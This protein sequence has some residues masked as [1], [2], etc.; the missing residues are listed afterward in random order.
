MFAVKSI[1]IVADLIEW[2]ACEL[3]LADDLAAKQRQLHKK[4]LLEFHPVAR[5]R[6]F[7]GRTGKMDRPQGLPAGH[8]ALGPHDLLRQRF[9]HERE[10]F[11]EKCRARR[12]YDFRRNAAFL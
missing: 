7:I 5:P 8:Q 1:E 2:I 11:F 4:E 10:G 9:P 12:A 6:Q 3:R